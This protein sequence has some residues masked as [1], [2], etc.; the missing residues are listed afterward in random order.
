[1][2]GFDRAWWIIPLVFVIV[3]IVWGPGRLPEVGSGLGRAIR[4]FRSAAT[5]AR[6]AVSGTA[7][8]QTPA[9]GSIPPSPVQPAAAAPVAAVPLQAAAPA[10]LDDG[11][12]G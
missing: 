6:E 11:S 9:S 2:F 12:R 8:V 10:A 4:E 1:M 5:G 3:L 7:N